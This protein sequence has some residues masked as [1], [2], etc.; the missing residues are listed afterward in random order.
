MRWCLRPGGGS[1]PCI[2]SVDGSRTGARSLDDRVAGNGLLDGGDGLLREVVVAG[3][4]QSD[5][6]HGQR[7]AQSE[8]AGI[9]HLGLVNMQLLQLR[10]CQH[11]DQGIDG[12]IGDLRAVQVED[13]DLGLRQHLHDVNGSGIADG[14]SAQHKRCEGRSRQRLR[15]CKHL[16]V[17]Q[18]IVA[19]V[20]LRQAHAFRQQRQKRTDVCQKIAI[21]KKLIDLSSTAEDSHELRKSF[22]KQL[23]VSEVVLDHCGRQLLP[24]FRPTDRVD[25]WVV[26]DAHA[27]DLCHRQKHAQPSKGSGI[28]IAPRQAQRV[29]LLRDP[30]HGV[31]DGRVR[32]PDLDVHA[33]GGHCQE[34]ALGGVAPDHGAVP[35]LRPAGGLLIHIHAAARG[36]PGGGGG[37]RGAVGGMA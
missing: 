29:E 31:D 12:A 4:E 30:A 14:I 25:A 27:P 8:H 32:G 18:A 2:D 22:I 17:V 7:S 13:V 20:Q 37:R 26:G 9:G 3:I 24:E 35:V 1:H 28:Q 34:D 19:H 23:V 15:Q 33:A 5:P 36:A 11:L 6:A 16:R 21:Q 10:V